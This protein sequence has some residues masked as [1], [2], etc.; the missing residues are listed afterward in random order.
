M[1]VKVSFMRPGT[2]GAVDAI[3]VGACRVCETLTLPG[4]TTAAAL[5][6][7]IVLMVSTETGACIAAH[8][9]TPSAVATTATA[10]TSAGYGIP[11]GVAIAV[12]VQGGDKIN[13]QA[14]A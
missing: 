3:G 8:G 11:T 10:A 6:G 9:S 2:L 7:E 14:F 1:P 13:V 5:P 12:A 4:T